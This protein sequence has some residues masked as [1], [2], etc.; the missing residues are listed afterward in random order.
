[1]KYFSQLAAGADVVPL[2][3]D[4]QRQPHLWNKNP[5]RL[6][7]RTPHHETQ[8][9]FLRYKDE[10]P[11][12]QSNDWQGY[13][14]EHIPEWYESID[15]LPSARPLIFDLMTRVR[16][17]MLGGVFIYKVEPGKRIYPHVDRGWHPAF[18]EKFN[19][20]LQSNPQAAFVYD[21]EAMVQRQGDVHWFRNDIRHEVINDGVSDHIVM[22]V[23]IRMDAGKRVPWSPEG[24]SMDKAMG[25]EDA[26]AFEEC[27]RARGEE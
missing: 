25:W 11:H 22:T 3:L 26:P 7:K 1:L 5:S 6:S 27:A 12:L 23:C 9:I 16:G 18:Y 10:R 17:E 15:H 20:C 4:L 2:L 8:D 13:S 21:G 19:V 14:D 24:W